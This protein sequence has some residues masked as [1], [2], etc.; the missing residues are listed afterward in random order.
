MRLKEGQ[1][2]LEEMYVVSGLINEMTS[3]L[4]TRSAPNPNAD[5]TVESVVGCLRKAH[6]IF[7]SLLVTDSSVFFPVRF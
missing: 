5:T 6:N 4:P 2:W 1:G 3:L 7:H